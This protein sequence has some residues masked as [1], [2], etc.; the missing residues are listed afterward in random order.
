VASFPVPSGEELATFY[1]GFLYRLP[2]AGTHRERQEVINR[3]AATILADCTR[4]AGKRPPFRLLDWGGGVGYYANGFAQLGCECTLIDID[5]KACEYASQSFGSRISVVNA[6]PAAH[7]FAEPF[8]VVFCSH[9]IEHVP[10]VAAFLAAMRRAL[11]P[12]GIAIL[13]TPNQ[14]CKEYFLRLEWFLSYLRM[15]ARTRGQLVRSFVKCMRKAWMCCDPPRHLHAFNRKSLSVAAKR[16]GFEVLTAFG[17]YFDAQD[18]QYSRFPMKWKWGGAKRMVG[19]AYR[20]Y[21]KLGFRTL[22]LLAPGGRWGSN[23][24]VYVRYPA[25]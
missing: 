25:P 12:G 11:V 7:S 5:A 8:D 6:D 10:D 23:L 9:V 14:E 15:T 17:E 13:S 3:C 1:D 21:A 16:A 19:N 20:I 4:I 24:V 2:A 18:Y 22:S